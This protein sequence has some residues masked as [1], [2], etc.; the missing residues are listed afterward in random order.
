MGRI[1]SASPA[2]ALVSDDPADVLTRLD[3]KVQLFEPDAMAT[4]AYAVLDPDRA[5]LEISSAGHLPLLVAGRDRPTRTLEVPPDLPVGAYK[6]VS[7]TSTKAS[8]DAGSCL[9]LYTDG[10]VERPDRSITAG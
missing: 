6:N 3:R 10:L 9:F 7:R 1:R 5:T 2:Y 8:V 4:V